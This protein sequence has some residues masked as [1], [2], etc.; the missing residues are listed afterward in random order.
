MHAER[1]ERSGAS[2]TDLHGKV[3]CHELRSEQGNIVIAKGRV[4]DDADVTHAFSLPWS[5]LHVLALDADDVHEDAAGDRIAR[6]VAGEGITIRSP[7]AGHWPLVAAHRGLLAI[8]GHV[9]ERINELDGPC[10]YSL[11]DGQVV[12]AGEV[13]AR[14]K[15]IPFA[16]TSRVL[17]DVES[18]VGADGAVRVRAFVPLRTGAIVHESLGDRAV[19]RF[20]DAVTEKL[21]WF[22]SSL[23]A[24]ETTRSNVDAIA[25]AFH[26][27]QRAGAQ[28][29]LVAG[30]K[31]MDV[32][33]PTFAA[34]D[35]I[36]AR[37][38]RHG[39]PAH[40]GSLLWL[41][42]WNGVPIVGMPTCGLFAQATVFDLVIARILT[43]DRVGRRELASLAQGGFL[44]REMA[45]RL[46]AYRAAADRGAVE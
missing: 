35:T 43:G 45:F 38:I 18:I 5:E 29:I 32:L 3:L 39:V 42:D 37:M 31:A 20:K 2:P 9:L 33:D 12:E 19:A 24:L 25:S 16:V 22:G 26:A 6:A 41:A 7:G 14:A 34:L 44:T 46:P 23:C 10:V 13:V 4:L 17:S 21:S 28:V 11:Y 15:I 30:T 27:T 36:G 1:V 8:D 40:P